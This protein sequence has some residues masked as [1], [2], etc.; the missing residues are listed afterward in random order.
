MKKHF[1]WLLPRNEPLELGPP[2]PTAG[3]EFD[4]PKAKLTYLRQLD[5][6]QCGSMHQGHQCGY[7]LHVS[8]IHVCS[9]KKL[10]WVR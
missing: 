9:C 1:L 7:R 3:M 4:N 5:S 6:D 2:D 8:Q 10:G